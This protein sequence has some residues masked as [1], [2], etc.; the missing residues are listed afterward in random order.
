ML[1]CVQLPPG[2]QS[3]THYPFWISL[4]VHVRLYTPMRG[5]I[6]VSLIRTLGF[7]VSTEFS[8]VLRSLCCFRGRGA[9]APSSISLFPHGQRGREGEGGQEREAVRVEDGIE[10]GGGWEKTSTCSMREAPQAQLAAVQFLWTADSSQRL[11]YSLA[12]SFHSLTLWWL[13]SI[14]RKNVLVLYSVVWSPTLL[15]E[16]GRERAREEREMKN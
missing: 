6:Q 8:P 4:H 14:K 13:N 1:A 3:R 10:G 16:R 11:L 2:S 5:R 12:T 7:A 15:R 9:P